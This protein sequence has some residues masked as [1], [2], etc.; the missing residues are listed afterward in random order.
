MM[1]GQSPLELDTNTEI[2]ALI[3]TLHNAGQRLEELTAGEVDAVTHPDGRTFLLQGAQEQLRQSEVAKQAAILNSLPANI[4]LLDSRGL[5]VSVN[6]GWRQF[7]QANA[8][9]SPDFGLGLDYLQ[10]CDA[11]PRENGHEAHPITE[12]IRSVLAGGE[13]RFSLEYACDSPSE[14]RWFLMTVTPLPGTPPKGAV[15]MHLN[16]TEHKKSERRIA[17]LNRVY[18]MLSGINTLI[19]RVNDRDDL[20]REACQ[21][22]VEA[23]GF[24]MALIALVDR[25]T[26]TIVPVASA[27][28][29]DEL[30][31]AI[32]GLLALSESAKTTMVAQAIREK[33]SIVSNHSQADSRLTLGK[34]YAEAGVRSMAI[35]P[36]IVAGE[37]V[38]V[39]TLYAS[40]IE[41][42]Q[43]EE[44]KLLSEL[45]GDIAFAMDHIDKQDR[46]L[47]L[48]Y[49]DVLTG[50]PN[51]V[52]L[53]DRLEQGLKAARRNESLLAVIFVDL[54][55][56]KRVNDTLGHSI[57]DTLLR[58]VASRLVLCVRDTDTVGRLGG[59]EFG[60]ILPGIGS[61]EDVAMVARKLIESCAR[62]HVIDGHELFVSA[63]VGITVFPDDATDS[64]NLVR[65]ADTAMYR[66]KD[67][68]RNTYQFF[69]VEMN[70]N[71]QSKMKLEG[72]LRHALAR[73][74]FLLHYQPKVS[75]STGKVTGFEALLRWQH[76]LRGLVGPMEFIPILE[77]TGLIVPVGEWVLNT[78]CL[79]AQ[80]WYDDGLGTL[81]MAVNVSGRQ[82]HLTDLCETVSKALASSG[83][84]PSCLE[85]ELTES[86][87]MQDV[88][89][90]IALLRRLKAMGVRLSVDDFGTGYSSLAYLKRFPIDC[91]KVDQAFVRDIIADAND[92]SITRA[93]ITLAHNL[94]LKV[95]AEG[96]E[97][98]GQLGL[99]IAN[100][101]DEVQGYYFSRPLPVDEATALLQ[102]G[103]SLD[104]KMMSSMKRKRTPLLADGEAS[105]LSCLKRLLRKDR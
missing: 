70:R 69:T 61:T 34:R 19:V 82:I 67:L 8:L 45:A 31:S 68:G 105:V 88:E 79:Q 28:K 85:L 98:E 24:R 36:L 33:K 46:L 9:Q 94:Q 95:V 35:F 65:N 1:A 89:G 29:D 42:F 48:A 99:L 57:G 40:E 102:T 91:L 104:S 78:A 90:I 54:D 93:I 63:S 21:I 49:Y 12:G 30:L 10:V 44:L 56:F 26:S 92:V 77:E 62:P 75:C 38:G 20:F 86:Q 84:A 103:R 101:C 97:T 39:I 23:G 22:A 66:A 64:E 83:L 59:D 74:E 25:D 50:R 53:Y 76:P 17:Y 27:G 43:D 51:R 3:E 55:N 81:S 15:V 41:F 58:E 73:S 18:A 71:T 96:V 32:E 60:I 14:Q 13:S 7:A 52:L 6:E 37:A 80:R 5:I 87:L 4:A 2:A 100:H 11:A 47:Y 72:D 16:I